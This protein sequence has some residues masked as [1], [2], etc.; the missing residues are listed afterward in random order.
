MTVWVRELLLERTT[1]YL[2]LGEIDERARSSAIASNEAK[3]NKFALCKLLGSEV[4]KIS[5]V[6]TDAELEVNGENR[7][8]NSRLR[9]EVTSSSKGLGHVSLECAVQLTSHPKR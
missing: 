1:Y 6:V 9:W 2:L 5:L 7:I 8:T 4:D 3:N